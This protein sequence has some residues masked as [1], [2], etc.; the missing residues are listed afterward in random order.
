MSRILGDWQT[1]WAMIAG[2][3]R[4]LV[5][6]RA[7]RTRSR[8]ACTWGRNQQ[9]AMRRFATQNADCQ[10]IEVLAQL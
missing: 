9:D 5:R 3:R 2:Q 4:F 10:N 6:G 1:A 7:S 8:Y